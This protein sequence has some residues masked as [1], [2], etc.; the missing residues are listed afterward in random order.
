MNCKL[1]N[2]ELFYNNEISK[3]TLDN[4]LIPFKNDVEYFKLIIDGRISVKMKSV[5]NFD[6]PDLLLAKDEE[7]TAALEE[8]EVDGS[9]GGNK[10]LKNL[11]EY[12]SFFE[13]HYKISKLT[14]ESRQDS[15]EFDYDFNIN[16]YIKNFKKA[17][18]SHYEKINQYKDNVFKALGKSVDVGFLIVD[19]FY[20]PVMFDENEYFNP[21]NS[22][23]I[24][25]FIER[26]QNVDFL[27]F[28]QKNA[29]NTPNLLFIHNSQNS[30]NYAKKHIKKVNESTIFT[31][32]R[33]KHVVIS[34][35]I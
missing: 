9:Q 25:S 14:N 13:N 34:L 28:Y 11:K 35:H 7:Y 10:G 3:I 21:L 22:Y 29:A 19:N 1:K 33:T 23:E 31:K 12:H 27:I 8:F 16:E 15:K 26:Y 30:L 6:S 32:P 5:F 20:N 24:I 2:E 18:L 17:F 4:W